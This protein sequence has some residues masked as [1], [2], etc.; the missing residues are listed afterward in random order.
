M[1]SFVYQYSTSCHLCSIT[2]ASSTS[3]LWGRSSSRASSPD[4]CCDVK[5]R[6]FAAPGIVARHVY[7]ADFTS[8]I[9]AYTSLE[10]NTTYTYFQNF[11]CTKYIATFTYHLDRMLVLAEAVSQYIPDSSFHYTDNHLCIVEY[12]PNVQKNHVRTPAQLS[13]LLLVVASPSGASW[14]LVGPH[15]G[16]VHVVGWL[17]YSQRRMRIQLSQMN[18][19]HW[20]ITYIESTII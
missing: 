16:Y 17:G 11:K 10:I 5:P 14:V 6:C 2:P 18:N 20:S 15:H 9:T 7:L 8:V 4:L 19:Y 12:C 1:H 13:L 3:N